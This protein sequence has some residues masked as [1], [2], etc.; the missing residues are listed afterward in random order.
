MVGWFKNVYPNHAAAAWSS[1]GVINPI[2][3]FK[4]FDTDIYLS[5]LKSGD[6]C[7]KQI[8]LMTSDI[9]RKLKYGSDEVKLATYNAITNKTLTDATKLPNIGDFM[10]YISDIFT[11]GVQYGGRVEMCNYLT[12]GT[13]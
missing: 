10:W 2:E 1:S 4:M 12:N 5:T 13:Y 6:E 7:P 9:E 8:N 11:M 3:N